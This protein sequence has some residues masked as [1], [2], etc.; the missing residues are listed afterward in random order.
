MVQQT[1]DFLSFYPCSEGS[2]FIC[3]ENVGPEYCCAYVQGS[4]LTGYDVSI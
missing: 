2:D 3:H 4:G 1:Q